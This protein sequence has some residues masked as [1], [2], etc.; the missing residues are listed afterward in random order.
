MKKKIVISLTL[1]ILFMFPL[2]NAYAYELNGSKFQ[3]P[4]KLTYYIDSSVNDA[5]YFTA[6]K[7]GIFAWDPLSEIAIYGTA[8]KVSSE[9]RMFYTNKDT[10]DYATASNECYCSTNDYS[11]ITFWKSMSKLDTTNQKETAVHEVGHSLGLKHEDDNRGTS[12]M[13]SGP[14]FINKTSPQ[15]DDIKGITAIY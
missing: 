1:M 15:S 13:L 5:G 3:A 9:I 4:K 11:N 8:G 12:I 10:G 7:H 6:A 2:T 14:A